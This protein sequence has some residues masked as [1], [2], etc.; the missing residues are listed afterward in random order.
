L[1]ILIAAIVISAGV[2][3]SSYLKISTTEIQTST[4]TTTVI[5]TSTVTSL[6]TVSGSCLVATNQTDTLSS[7]GFQAEIKYTSQ[8]NAVVMG[9]TNASSTPALMRCYLG[10]GIS[11]ILIP[12]WNINAESAESALSITVYKLDGGNGNLTVILGNDRNS[13][14]GPYGSVTVGEDVYSSTN[15]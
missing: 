13:T 9:Y 12:N 7:A 4:E 11:F 6:M 2:L 10:S 3:T 1:A 14:T 5:Q 8:W 15:G